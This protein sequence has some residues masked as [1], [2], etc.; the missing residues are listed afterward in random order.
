[1]HATNISLFTIPMKEYHRSFQSHPCRP[2]HPVQPLLFIAQLVPKRAD[3]VVSGG[4]IAACAN[5]H[6]SKDA[7]GQFVQTRGLTTLRYLSRERCA[8]YPSQDIL[9][10]I[11]FDEHRAHALL[12]I[13]RVDDEL[14]AGVLVRIE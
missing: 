8:S 7:R 12:H 1:M 10:Q 14:P 2:I 6:P 5:A 13:L 4:Y 9:G 3:T 11:A